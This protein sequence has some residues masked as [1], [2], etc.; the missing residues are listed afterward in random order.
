MSDDKGLQVI[1]RGS[2]AVE[3][4]GTTYTSPAAAYLAG[5]SKTGRRTMQGTLDKVARLLGYADLWVTPWASLRY[6]HVQA[7]RTKLIEDGSKPATVNKTLS[8]IR[9]VL[10]AA[11]QMATSMR[12][13]TSAWR[14]SR[15]LPAPRCRLAVASGPVSSWP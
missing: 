4:A 13:H 14:W 11:W 9:G 1:E 3:I 2:G 12:T 10:K 5:L 15:A 8:A 6:E 7:I